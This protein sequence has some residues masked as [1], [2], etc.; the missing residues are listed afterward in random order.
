ITTSGPSYNPNLH[1]HDVTLPGTAA[2]VDNTD[3]WEAALRYAGEFNGVRLAAGVGYRH[4]DAVD[5]NDHDVWLGSG[6]VMHMPTGLF[7]SGGLAQI[8]WDDGE[9][10]DGFWVMAG[11]EKNFFGYGTTTLYG[12]YSESNTNF[13]GDGNFWGLGVV[14]RIDAAATDLFVKYR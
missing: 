6:S 10:Q 4:G 2:V 13:A 12:E 5:G 3:Y 8:E 7:V 1:T 14:Q 9:E 11:I